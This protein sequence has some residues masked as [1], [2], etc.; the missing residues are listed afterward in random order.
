MCKRIDTAQ[1]LNIGRLFVGDTHK[2][3]NGPVTT[4]DTVTV[5]MADDITFYIKD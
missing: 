4:R 1:K 2:L 3:N 5:E